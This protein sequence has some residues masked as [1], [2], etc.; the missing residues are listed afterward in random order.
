MILVL[1]LAWRAGD[2]CTFFA[3]SARQVVAQL[4]LKLQ[5]WAAS[6]LMCEGGKSIYGVPGGFSWGFSSIAA[7]PMATRGISGFPFWSSRITV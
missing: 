3:A 2:A 5:E 6:M 7:H 4:G 1:K